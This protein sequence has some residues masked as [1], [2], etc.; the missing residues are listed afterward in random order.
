MDKDINHPIGCLCPDCMGD[1]EPGSEVVKIK[2]VDWMYE[3]K[4]T[5]ERMYNTLFPLSKVNFV[6][7]FP[8]KIEAIRDK[9]LSFD[10]LR[11]IIEVEVYFSKR[12]DYIDP[13][14]HVAKAIL[15]KY[16]VVEK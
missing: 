11:H 1:N 5:E 6:R 10:E 8:N 14:G 4:M 7:I 13:I 3:D 9:E 15:S 2:I 16:K 12:D